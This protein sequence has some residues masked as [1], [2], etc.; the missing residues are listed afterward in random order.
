[1]T[2]AASTVDLAALDMIE[3]LDAYLNSDAS[4]AWTDVHRWACGQ[5]GA[6]LA[7]CAGLN[8][9]V[10]ASGTHAPKIATLAG[11]CAALWRSTTAQS[12]ACPLAP[13]WQ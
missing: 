4:Y 2:T 8:P 1:M 12:W 11:S 6:A 3:P 10:I 9:K 13:T 5:G 7:N